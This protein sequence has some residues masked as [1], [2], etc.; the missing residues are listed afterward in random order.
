MLYVVMSGKKGTTG[1]IFEDGV[2]LEMG[3]R[4]L[5]GQNYITFNINGV[6][7]L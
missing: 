5:M 2:E 1:Q 6:S 7:Y 4:F 3:Y